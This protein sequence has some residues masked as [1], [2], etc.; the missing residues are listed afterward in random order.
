MGP[1][2]CL[3]VLA[4][5]NFVGRGGYRMTSA[6]FISSAVP[7]GTAH[8]QVQRHFINCYIALCGAMVN[9]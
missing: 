6:Q 3:D 7:F 2:E 8:I 4:K 1:R 9:K 5:G